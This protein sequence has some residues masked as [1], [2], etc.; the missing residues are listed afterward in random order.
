MN[1]FLRLWSYINGVRI[2]S[3]N[4]AL[5]GRLE[6]WCK[7]GHLVLESENATYSYGALGD[8]FEVGFQKI[9]LSSRDI[10]TGLL[11]GFGVGSVASILTTSLPAPIRID[12]VE[13]DPVIVSL[14]ENILT[15]GNSNPSFVFLLKMPSGLYTTAPTAMT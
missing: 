9:S 2:D 4:S 15:S 14:G 11:L 13:H 10:R 8:I 3:Q 6:V 5:N 12:A 1:F 7:Y